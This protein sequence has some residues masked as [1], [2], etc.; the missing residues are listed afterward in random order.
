MGGVHMVTSYP[1]RT[2]PVLRGGWILETMLGVRVPSPPPDVPEIKRGK[3]SELSTR[4]ILKKHR[5]A[6]SCAACH[7][8]M[9]PLGFALDNFDVLGRWRDKEGKA[10]IDASAS[11]PSG[12]EFGGPE[13]LRQ[14]L[15]SRKKQFL[16]H[17]TRKMLGYALGRSLNDADDCTIQKI[18]A[19]VEQENYQSRTLVREI[20]LSLP[21]RYQQQTEHMVE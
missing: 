1:T 3:N 14:V 5:E 11:L 2:S 17:L 19:I 13:G 12:E 21:F 20:V 4:D 6:P 8:L 16:H 10:E 7:N 18:A 9:D 15:M